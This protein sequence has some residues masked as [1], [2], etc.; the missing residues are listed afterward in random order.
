MVE[1]VADNTKLRRRAV[2]I[3]AAAAG[4]DLSRA[5]NALTDAGGDTK[6]AIVGLVTGTSAQEARRRLNLA[7]GHVRAAI[8]VRSTAH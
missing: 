7:N 8:S 4:V 6:V 3:V 1:V 5:E 2:R